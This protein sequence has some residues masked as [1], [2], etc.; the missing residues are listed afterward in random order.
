MNK[1]AVLAFSLL[2]FLSAILWYLAKGSLDD[3]L[4][5]Q[6]ILQGHYYSGQ[7]TRIGQA[8]Y[9]PETN[10][11]LFSQFSL[12]NLKG[13]TQSEALIIDKIS[14]AL[15]S[16]QESTQPQQL[17]RGLSAS[18]IIT[19]EQLTL[20][21][22]S[23]NFEVRDNSTSNIANLNKLV[24]L[25]LAKDYPALYPNVAAKLYAKE[26]PELDAELIKKSHVATAPNEK[27]EVN[28]AVI[29]SKAE[30]KQNKLLGK[31]KTRIAVQAIIINELTLTVTQNKQTKVYSFKGVSL[32]EV[33]DVNGLAS[34]Q[35]GGEILRRLLEKVQAMKP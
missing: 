5:S 13:Y 28:K 9:I 35:V 15:L 31:A 3:Y 8:Q 22:V 10:I 23:V 1:L 21:K 24:T 4:R 32:G 19:V 6:V 27:T 20:N 25:Q 26:H 16:P 11:A 12:T 7:Q 2:L 17:T 30:R 18:Q 14:A 34:N 33:G 29:A